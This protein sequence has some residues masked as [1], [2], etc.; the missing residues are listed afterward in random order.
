MQAW[1]EHVERIVG[2]ALE[3]DVGKGDI[4]TD[5]IY[6]GNETGSA[7][8]VA[9]ENG[10]LA[11]L[12]LVPYIVSQLD[13]N[14]TIQTG[15]ND[16]D[17]VIAG[18]VIASFEGPLA[19]ML[20]AERTLLNFFQRMCGIATRTRE[21]VQAL[22]STRTKILDTRKT[23][24]GLRYLDKLAVR[25][26]G[27]ENHRMRLDD[28]F[29]IKEN[30][31]TMAGGIAQAINRCMEYRSSHNLE[32]AIEIE[33]ANLRELED[34]L[35]GEKVDYVMLDNMPLHEMRSAVERIDGRILTEASGNVT[36]DRLSEIAATGVDFISSGSLTHSVR[37]MDI[38]MLVNNR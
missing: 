30:H 34:V 35:A 38:S 32:A 9:K 13:K 20:S 21:Y 31:I 18:S 6:S 5:A 25:A 10:V 33:V 12:G 3:E 28:R 4:T 1:P 22:S 11:G 19:P 16:G 36:L 17:T 27:G 15:L 23:V 29:L 2:L 14:V 26:G 24:P 7:V 37:A 8:L